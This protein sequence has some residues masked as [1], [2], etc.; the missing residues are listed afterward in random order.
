MHLPKPYLSARQSR[1]RDPDAYENLLGDA[2]ERCFAQGVQDVEALVSHL[3]EL[4]VPAPGG[5]LW[6][7]ALLQHELERLGA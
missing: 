1:V 6:T 2:L 3:N 4:C 7:Q 5:Q